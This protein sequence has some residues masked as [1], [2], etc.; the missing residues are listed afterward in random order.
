M[1]T[2]QKLGMGVI[3]VAMMTTLVLPG[4]QT[5]KVIDAG[6]RFVTRTLGVA[7]GQKAK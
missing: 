7:M 2:A 3:A 1:S 4:R 5:G 6:T